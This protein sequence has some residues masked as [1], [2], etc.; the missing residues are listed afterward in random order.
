MEKT[1]SKTSKMK[2]KRRSRRFTKNWGYNQASTKL[3][4]ARVSLSEAKIALQDSR[5]RSYR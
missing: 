5:G 3:K 1:S 4:D 2:Q